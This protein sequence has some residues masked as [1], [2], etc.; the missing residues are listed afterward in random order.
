M[1]Q[2]CW[3]S[4]TF[5]DLRLSIVPMVSMSFHRFVGLLLQNLLQAATT[6]IYPARRGKGHLFSLRIA[7]ESVRG[8]WSPSL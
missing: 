2:I 3:K 4:S 1:F 6:W 5:R 8:S 7:D